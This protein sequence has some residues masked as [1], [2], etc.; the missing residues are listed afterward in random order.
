MKIFR[1]KFIVFV[2]LIDFQGTRAI[3]REK[4]FSNKQ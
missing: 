1:Q 4:K 2:Q 3:S